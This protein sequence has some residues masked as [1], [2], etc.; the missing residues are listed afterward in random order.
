MKIEAD[1]SGVMY[2]DMDEI[3][4]CIDNKERFQIMAYIGSRE[5][6]NE[7][8]VDCVS[9]WVENVDR[10]KACTSMFDMN[11]SEARLFSK[12]LIA[13]ADEIDKNKS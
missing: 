9:V 8:T 6:H 7:D 3:K 12:G 13:I 4:K 2:D 10:D 11:E 1:I 5:D